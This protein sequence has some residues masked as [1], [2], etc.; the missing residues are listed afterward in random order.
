MVRGIGSL[1][2]VSALVV[3][4][5]SLAPAQEGPSVSGPVA[6][7]FATRD[8]VEL[9]AYVF[10]PVERPADKPLA[11]IIVFHGG[12]WAIGEATWAFGYAR[13]F[14]GQGMVAVAAQYRL[15]DQTTMMICPET[16]LIT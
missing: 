6:H 11:A 13:R 1:I 8:S 4:G 15:S 12:G 7:V 14:A 3:L 5:S 2:V 16:P 9:K 10:A